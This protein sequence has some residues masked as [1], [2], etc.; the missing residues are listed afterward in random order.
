MLYISDEN[1]VIT[2]ARELSELQSAQVTSDLSLSTKTDVC[3]QADQRFFEDYPS[4][5]SAIKQ[6]IEDKQT[7]PTDVTEDYYFGVSVDMDRIEINNLISKYHFEHIKNKSQSLDKLFEYTNNSYSCIIG[8]GQDYYELRFALKSLDKV[9]RDRGHVPIQIT[10]ELVSKVENPPS[11]LLTH[12]S[13]NN[14]AVFYNELDLKI[15]IDIQAK[16]IRNDSIV[17]LPNKQSN[18][19]LRPDWSSLEDQV[20]HYQV[21]EYPWIKGDISVSWQYTNECLNKEIAKSLYLQSDFEAKFPSYLPE[22]FRLACNV[23]NTGSSFIQIYVNQEAIDYHTRKGEL[24]SRNNPFPIFLY[25]ST[26]DEEANGIIEI[27]AE[28]QYE[29]NQMDPLRESYQNLLA[30]PGILK[31]VEFVEEKDIAYL[32]YHEGKLSVISVAT[33]DDGYR[34]TGMMSMDELMQIAKSLS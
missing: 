2:K 7:F 24:H 11:R 21:K 6:I 22:G 3:I 26:P 23:H 34:L 32:S 8:D 18:L 27:Y 31:G 19:F 25:S 20:Y 12:A 5:D 14:T 15:T 28:K 16:G 13:F 30:K 10:K 17:L 9:T 29:G 33:K 4:I 1:S